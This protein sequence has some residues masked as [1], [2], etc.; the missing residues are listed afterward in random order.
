MN[1]KEKIEEIYKLS[2]EL[3]FKVADNRMLACGHPGVSGNNS[4]EKFCPG[5]GMLIGTIEVLK[6]VAEKIKKDSE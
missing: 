6:Q 5:Y 1:M 4:D 2:V 3:W